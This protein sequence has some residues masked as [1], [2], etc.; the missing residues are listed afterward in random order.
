MRMEEKRNCTRFARSV[1]VKLKVLNMVSEKTYTSHYYMTRNICAEGAFIISKQHIP[2]G[3]EI[4]AEIGFPM[5]K[6]FYFFSGDHC[7]VKVKG[8]VL[9]CESTGMAICFQKN[10]NVEFVGLPTYTKYCQT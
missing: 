5:A 7:F 1:P 2:E 3:T 10:C 6:T 4:I 9:R 8:S